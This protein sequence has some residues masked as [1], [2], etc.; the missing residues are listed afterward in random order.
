MRN[1]FYVLI[2][3]LM[4]VLAATVSAQEAEKGTEGQ[5]QM[6]PMGPP[7]EMQQLSDLVGDWDVDMKMGM[8]PDTTTWEHSTG[9]CAYSY[10]LDG[11]AMQMDYQGTA[12]GMPFL[13][14]GLQ[15]Y[16]RETGMWQMTWTDNMSARISMYTGKMENGKTVITGEDLYNGEKF[17]TRITTFNQTKNSFDWKMEYSTDGGKTFLPSAYAKYTKQ[18]R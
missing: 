2:G 8:N 13:G 17:L 14:I 12:M 5:Q 6:P 3:L 18:G 16:D 15:C 4:I 10:I 7:T 9:T 1:K 11:A